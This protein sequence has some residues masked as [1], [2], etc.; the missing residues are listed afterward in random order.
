MAATLLVMAPVIIVFFFAQ[1]AFVEGVTLTGSRDEAGRRG[2]RIHLHAG[3]GRRVRPSGRRAPGRRAGADRPGRRA[4]RAG[5]RAGGPHSRGPRT[6]GSPPHDDRPR[7]R[8]VEDADAVLLQ[9]RVGGQRPARATRRGRSSAAA[10]ARRRRVQAGSRRRCGR[11]R[12]CSTSPS[13]WRAATRRPGSSTSPTPSAS[14]PAPCCRPDTGPSACATSRS[15]SSA[16]FAAMLGVPAGGRR[17]GPR[18]PQ[19]PH[20]G[21]RRP[22]RW[23]R[24]PPAAA[25]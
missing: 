12:W 5:R 2:W 8:R 21:T 3:A 17:A 19:P 7:R 6:P 11:C 16:R 14:S 4:A 23:P 1:R 25:G 9:L 20:L 22:S 10:S 24:R 18:R 15:D 13:R